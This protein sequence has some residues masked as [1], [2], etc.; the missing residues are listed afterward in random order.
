[1]TLT[2]FVLR[3]IALAILLAVLA[4]I[5]VVVYSP[6]SHAQTALEFAAQGMGSPSLQKTQRSACRAAT[7]RSRRC[8]ALDRR[9]ASRPLRS[10]GMLAGVYAPLAAK[11]REIESAC[12]SVVI[13]GRRH[14]RVAGSR[15]WS[16]HASGHAV[17]MRGNP[18]CIYAH[19]RGFGGGYSTDYGRVRHVHIS[20]GGR[21][22]GL[23]FAHHH[24]RR[25]HRY[26]SR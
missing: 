5:L 21:E 15:R 9:F 19:L 23:R 25:H 12:G 22:D 17:D 26:A 24:V 6:S 4:F 18:G 10:E 8:A 1:M 7:S 16:L 13:S 3:A 14:T 20:L 11:A 2:R